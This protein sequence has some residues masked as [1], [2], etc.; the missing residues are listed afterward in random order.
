VGHGCEGSKKLRI[1]MGIGGRISSSSLTC[2]RGVQRNWRS[3]RRGDMK[4]SCLHLRQTWTS[5]FHIHGS[6]PESIRQKSNMSRRTSS[7]SMSNV[8][9][10]AT[11]PELAIAADVAQMAYLDPV[12][13]SMPSW[14]RIA[15]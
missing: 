3:N 8:T 9:R 15:W 5:V 7:G 14:E 6:Q 2:V 4:M 10:P 13:R 11:Y 12:V 1:M